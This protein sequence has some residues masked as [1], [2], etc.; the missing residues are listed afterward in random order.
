MH[1]PKDSRA[2]TTAVSRRR[3]IAAATAVAAGGAFAA[4]GRALGQATPDASPVAGGWSFTD[5]IGNTVTLPKPPQR[6]AAAI[7]VAASLWD[8]GVEVPTVFGWTASNHP[9]GDH[10]AWGN[11]DV[12]T[13]AIVSD[14]EGNIEVEPLL[15]AAPDLIVT[16]TWDKDDPDNAL[17]ALPAKLM[18][19]VSQIAPVVVLNQGDSNEVELARVEQFAASLGVDL[20]AP[21]LV[22]AREAYEA[23][24]AELEQVAAEKAGLLVL[25]GSF[26]EDMIYVASPDYVGDLG[27]VRELGVAIANDGSAAGDT[28]WESLSTE[29][30][31]Q[32]PSDVLYIDQYGAWTT[33]EELQGHPTIAQHPAVKAGQTAPWPRDLPLSYEGMTAFLESV[34]A[35]LRTAE[36]VS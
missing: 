23:K 6:I 2:H 15:V 24:A 29:N 4:T 34:L 30:A 19:A 16:W 12:E 11:I 33:V 14:T 27:M 17:V 5:A 9:D 3:V 36:K 8:F 28:Y 26:G 13:V 32:Y 35:P 20:D 10:V 18:D 21:E 25:F 22:A 31:L 7:N 1:V